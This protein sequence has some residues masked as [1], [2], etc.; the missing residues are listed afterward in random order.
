MDAINEDD[1]KSVDYSQHIKESWVDSFTQLC[2]TADCMVEFFC[3]NL[4]KVPG[5]WEEITEE[6]LKNQ[7]KFNCMNEAWRFREYLYTQNLEG[8]CDFSF[9][10]VQFTNPGWEHASVSTTQENTTQR[11]TT[12]DEPTEDYDYY[13]SEDGFVNAI[14]DQE[15]TD[16]KQ[17]FHDEDNI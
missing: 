16:V 15:E 9:I 8:I 6:S 11:Q 7:L 2:D 5:Y 3:G 13:T 17:M 12:T 1:M 10:P 14:K 4:I